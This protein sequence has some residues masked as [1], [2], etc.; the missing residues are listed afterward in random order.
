MGSIEGALRGVRCI[1]NEIVA[2]LFDRNTERT[3]DASAC[4]RN[5]CFRDA[6][7]GTESRLRIAQ[8]W[9]N[10]LLGAELEWSAGRRYDGESL[11][12]NAGDEVE[13]LSSRATAR[14]LGR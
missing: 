3:F 4:L 12:A 13:M 8:R 14:D 7:G 5:V 2:V 10:V 9:P 6:R 11:G 1:C